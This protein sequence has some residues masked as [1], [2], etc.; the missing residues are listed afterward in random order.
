MDA[1]AFIEAFY[2][3]EQAS[4]LS[5]LKLRVTRGAFSGYSSLENPLHSPAMCGNLR[6]G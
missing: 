2:I 5:R 4:A 3:N 6:L 1:L